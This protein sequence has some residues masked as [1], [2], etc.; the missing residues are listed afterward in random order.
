MRYFKVEIVT[1]RS[2]MNARIFASD[3]AEEYFGKICCSMG[4]NECII[5]NHGVPVFLDETL[6]NVLRLRVDPIFAAPRGL[7]RWI[8]RFDSIRPGRLF[9]EVKLPKIYEI[10]RVSVSFG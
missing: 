1:H 7:A 3:L 8:S 6:R 4:R 2:P 5:V 10:D 9:R